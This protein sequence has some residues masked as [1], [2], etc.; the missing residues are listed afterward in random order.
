M[1]TIL[2][3]DDDPHILHSLKMGLLTNG[4]KTIEASDGPTALALLSEQ[5][6]DIDIVV[7]DYLMPKM[8]G[9]ELLHAAKGHDN[10]IPIILI[11]AYG[12]KKLVVKALQHGCD[13]FLEK[14]FTMNE[15]LSE[16]ERIQQVQND[17]QPTRTIERLLPRIIHQIN[18]PL[19]VINGH[20]QLSLLK[21][22]EKETLKKNLTLIM[23]A[24]SMISGINKKIMHLGRGAIRLKKRQFDLVDLLD[25]VIS[26]FSGF[27][28][29]NDVTLSKNFPEE[30]VNIVGDQ[31]CLGDVFKNL[32]VNGIEA[33]AGCPEK[34]MNI[35]LVIS[36]DRNNALLVI[37]DNGCGI[38]TDQIEDIFKPYNTSKIHGTG[39]GLA[40]AREIVNEHNG[41][42]KVTSTSGH[43]TCFML[44]L[45]LPKT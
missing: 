45:P 8:N 11:T 4:Y 19:H 32:L 3:V 13:G 42:I 18:N 30:V 21:I 10:S 7:T 38:P 25:S 22:E 9:M 40:I 5:R 37:S 15:L 34:V 24:T 39:L 44:T 27:L 6:T 35:D 41:T 36:D 23:Q 43:G 29:V 33:M 16:I 28:S 12:D 2:L 20:A 1:N 31:G 14:P 26:E 17:K